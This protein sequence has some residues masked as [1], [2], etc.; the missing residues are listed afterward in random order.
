M[1]RVYL[2]LAKTDPIY[3]S[4]DRAKLLL[5]DKELFEQK[6]L[7]NNWMDVDAFHGYLSDIRSIVLDEE[8]KRNNPTTN[9]VSMTDEEREYQRKKIK[10][11]GKNLFGDKYKS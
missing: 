2:K 5:K 10:E 1:A 8:T 11:I 6:K 9:Y 7:E 4:N 3:I